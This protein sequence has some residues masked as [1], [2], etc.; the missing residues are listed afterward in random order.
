MILTNFYYNRKDGYYPMDIYMTMLIDD[1]TRK[2]MEAYHEDDINNEASKNIVF[3]IFEKIESFMGWLYNII[4]NLINSFSMLFNRANKSMKTFASRV[5][6]SDVHGYVDYIKQGT[7]LLRINYRHL[8]KIRELDMNI[9]KEMSMLAAMKERMKDMAL[10]S[11]DEMTT[12]QYYEDIHRH[13]KEVEQCSGALDNIIKTAN[14]ERVVTPIKR[15]TKENL[16][17]ELSLP[18]KSI[19]SQL[20]ELKDDVKNAKETYR[21][22]KRLYKFF[23]KSDIERTNKLLNYT[24]N[25]LKQSEEI[26]AIYIKTISYIEEVSSENVK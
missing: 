25:T 15:Y 2:A 3:K 26:E 12:R 19:I 11:K 13:F 1:D 10:R 6:I 8:K 9:V 20:K 17:R 22:R 18:L 7:E 21:E 23:H 16:E 24:S 5:I 4:V 14:E